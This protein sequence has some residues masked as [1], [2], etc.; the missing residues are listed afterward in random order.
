VTDLGVR[1]GAGNSFAAFGDIRVAALELLPPQILAHTFRPSTLESGASGGSAGGDIHID[2]LRTWVDDPF[3][4]NPPDDVTFDL[5]TI[6]LHEAGHALGLAHSSSADSVMVSEYRGARRSLS[7]DDIAGIRA[8]YAT[9]E[10]SSFW[11]VAMGIVWI[12]LTRRRRS[13]GMLGCSEETLRCR[14][15]A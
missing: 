13:C 3:D 15:G 14:D 5:Y 2:V 4:A 11:G 12:S 8:L 7:A 1:L 9:P 6:L 10:P